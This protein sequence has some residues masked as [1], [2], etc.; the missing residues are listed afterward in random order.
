MTVP[1]GFDPE[2]AD[3][4][5]QRAFSYLL[6][7]QSRHYIGIMDI[8]EAAVNDVTAL[9]VSQGLAQVGIET[10]V[11]DV[12]QRLMQLREWH[13]VLGRPDSSGLRVAADLLKRNWRFAATRLGRQI[14]RFYRATLN[15]DPVVREVAL[16]SLQRIISALGAL[17]SR[18][19]DNDSLSNITTTDDGGT[20]SGSLVT[21][22]FVDHDALDQSLIGAEESLT[23]LADRFDLDL[24]ATLELKSMLVGY[25]THLANELDRG[26]A[27]VREYLDLLEPHIPVL[28]Q[29][30]V[31]ASSAREL[32]ER[33]AL[34]ASRG[35]N[36][37]DWEALAAWFH[38]SSGRTARF[39]LSM[40]QA[41]PGMHANLRRQHSASSIATNRSRSLALARAS[42]NAEFGAAITVAALGDHSWRKLHGVADDE[43]T[44][45]SVPWRLGPKVEIPELLRLI[46]RSGPRGKFPTVPD[47]TRWRELAEHNRRNRDARQRS[48]VEEI[49]QLDL[50]LTGGI[51]E[52]SDHAAREA[53][54]VLML[55]V[56]GRPVRGVRHAAR[57]GLACSVVRVRGRTGCISAPTWRVLLPGRVIVF[58]GPR[59]SITLP[60]DVEADHSER[61]V[62]IVQRSNS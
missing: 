54:S 23:G 13:V 48:G 62:L 36:P 9:E 33:G 31:E 55:A 19:V 50:K 35:G 24:Q 49:L 20:P 37:N 60:T 34:Q 39:S 45:G 11:A 40:V 32:I 47:D 57:H 3:D 8:L 26:A 22:L 15:A 59:Q 5:P 1:E 42:L 41:L 25:A 56:R 53:M 28:A 29:T 46:G 4:A 18:F 21:Q 16:P 43:Q 10:S 51:Y 6:A 2:L 30:T 17:T 61:P 12:E 58:H 52:V 44:T 27:L 7:P 14:Q 38:S